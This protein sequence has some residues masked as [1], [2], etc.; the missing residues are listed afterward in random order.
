LGDVPAPLFRRAQ[1]PTP[2]PPPPPPFRQTI[3][4]FVYIPA[5]SQRALDAGTPWEE[6]IGFRKLFTWSESDLPAV[7]GGGDPLHLWSYDSRAWTGRGE[8]YDV[9]I[10]VLLSAQMMVFRS[11]DFKHIVEYVHEKSSR[12]RTQAEAL[13]ALKMQHTREAYVVVRAEKVRRANRCDEL[14]KQREARMNF[15][16]KLAQGDLEQQQQQQQQLGS[17]GS[18]SKASGSAKMAMAARAMIMTRRQMSTRFLLESAASKDQQSVSEAASAAASSAPP[19]AAELSAQRAAQQQ[20]RQALSHRGSGRWASFRE[21]T[22]PLPKAQQRVH[23]AGEE[24]SSQSSQS[25]A[26]SSD[27]EE[28]VAADAGEFSAGDHSGELTDHGEL[29]EMKLL[30][31]AADDERRQADGE[32]ESEE[33]EQ[34]AEQAEASWAAK[35]LAGVR[36]AWGKAKE[37][38]DLAVDYVYAQGSRKERDREQYGRM[39]GVVRAG[40]DFLE[41]NS[42]VIVYLAFIA[43]TTASGN[44]LSMMYPFA[45]FGFAMLEY[46]MPPAPFWTFILSYSNLV[47]VLKFLFTLIGIGSDSTLHSLS[48][49]GLQTINPPFLQG[50]VWDLLLWLAVLWHK[51]MLKQKGFWTM[52]R[53]EL[54]TAFPSGALIALQMKQGVEDAQPAHLNGEAASGDPDASA[55]L[56][57]VTVS[58]GL[59]PRRSRSRNRSRSRTHG[60]TG[61][62]GESSLR[63]RYQRG[64]SEE[65]AEEVEAE[66]SLAAGKRRSAAG[67][68]HLHDEDLIADGL[69]VDPAQER[70]ATDEAEEESSLGRSKAAVRRTASRV[71]AYYTDIVG[72]QCPGSGDYYVPILFIDVLSF[73]FLLLFQ[74]EFTGIPSEEIPDFISDGRIPRQYLFLLFA[75]FLLLVCERALY[76]NRNI[77][78]KLG[79]QYVLLFAYHFLLFYYLPASNG[80]PF[81]HSW[82][83]IVFYLMKC[84]YFWVSGMQIRSGYPLVIDQRLLTKDTSTIRYGAFQVYRAIPFVYEMR[85]LLDWTIHDTTLGFYMWLKFEDIYAQLYETQ[86]RVDSYERDDRKHG[87]PQKMVRKRACVVWCGVRWSVVIV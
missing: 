80:T 44:L 56:Q 78:G 48:W 64:I 6:V 38:S 82:Q 76:L 2:P 57:E 35:V 11:P 8:I 40:F 45:A 1:H 60:H 53:E 58:S 19:S 5:P 62:S 71:G 10:F 81:T 73:V 52:S 33:G 27:E 39:H 47:I 68:N 61:A 87:Q 31:E 65:A 30:D 17:S 59:T 37:W 74:Q 41:R 86:Y 63:H 23:D 83:L 46:P 16:G 18:L 85:C 49:L 50:V 51:H 79:L 43:N 14:R 70:V 29:L 7:N 77:K 28:V 84:C 75:Q 66:Q 22:Q 21:Y 72:R 15:Y 54:K 34:A 4:Q 25:S 36:F 3:Y 24:H 67:N 12:A 20:H 9:I 42:Y 69:H 32:Q 26:S 55:L 13:A